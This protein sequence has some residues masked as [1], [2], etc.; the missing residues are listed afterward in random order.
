MRQ[1]GPQWISEFRCLRGHFSFEQLASLQQRCRNRITGF[2]VLRHPESHVLSEYHMVRTDPNAPGHKSAV[3]GDLSFEEYLETPQ[4]L[5]C[6]EENRMFPGQRPGNRQCAHLLLQDDENPYLLPEDEWLPRVFEKLEAYLLV[7]LQER[8]SESVQLLAFLLGWECPAS[9][10]RANAARGQKPVLTD[11]QRRRLREIN[12]L[13]FAL[14]EWALERFDRQYASLIAELGV[15]DGDQTH[16]IQVSDALRDRSQRRR[17]ARLRE[18]RHD[19][20]YVEVIDATGLLLGHVSR[21]LNRQLNWIGPDRKATVRLCFSTPGSR[22]LHIE[23]LYWLTPR[24]LNDFSVLVNG[25]PIQ[26][27]RHQESSSTHFVGFL[28]DYLL[29]PPGDVV[30]IALGTS[31]VASPAALGLNACDDEQKCV[32][33]ASL[34]CFPAR[35]PHLGCRDDSFI[36]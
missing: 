21:D 17:T 30:E 34:N 3:E 25:Q 4:Y 19:A 22:V 31:G 27:T 6:T 1:M 29:G 35:T 12:R 28:P 10:P 8:L 24:M 26:M 23:L 20:H 11:A 7:G 15:P 32:A 13:D 2:T 36:A 18:A 33:L 14:Y 9:L 5:C 16:A